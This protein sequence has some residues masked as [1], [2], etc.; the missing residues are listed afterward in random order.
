MLTLLTRVTN[1]VKTRNRSLD[2]LNTVI[3]SADFERVPLEGTGR[4]RLRGQR[5]RIAARRRSGKHV[6]KHFSGDKRMTRLSSSYR[7]LFIR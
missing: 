7:N 1:R 6:F 3:I 2:D 5:K 4:V